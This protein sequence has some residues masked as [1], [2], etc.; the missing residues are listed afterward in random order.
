M[1]YRLFYTKRAV[2]DIAKLDLVV[3]KRI[4]KKLLLYAQN[5]LKY[6][7]KLTD[8]TIG[9]YRFRIGDYRVIFDLK[10][11]DIIVLRLGHRKDIYRQ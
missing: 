5:P 4:G 3:K 11:R 6:A 10:G 9:T 7:T 2:N 1:V 8:Y